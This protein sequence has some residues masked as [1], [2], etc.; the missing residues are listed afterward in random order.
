MSQFLLASASSPP[1]DFD[2][3]FSFVWISVSK[4]LACT[5]RIWDLAVGARWPWAILWWRFFF[6]SA[7]AVGEISTPTISKCEILVERMACR[8]KGIHPVPVHRSRILRRVV[9]KLSAAKGGIDVELLRD[10]ASSESSINLA[11]RIV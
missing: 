11:I 9:G 8:R 7:M 3:D 2:F 6:A 4:M 10:C 5:K 1:S